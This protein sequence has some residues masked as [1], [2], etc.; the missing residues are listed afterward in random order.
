MTAV[1][2]RPATTSRA[3]PTGTIHIVDPSPLNWLFITWN[4]M[5]E[6]VRTDQDGRIV[7][8]LAESSRWIDERT[9]ELRLRSGVQFQDGERF[10]AHNIKQHFDEMQRW[11]APH[12]PGTWLNFPPESV[13]EVADD[14]TI[15]FHL[16]EPDALAPT[17]FSGFHIASSA[18]WGPNGP[19][20]GYK[21]FGSATATG[22]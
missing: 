16:P 19:G 20:F 6:P 4:T 5:E 17:K 11:P 1:E 9:L 7:H 2:E 22:E 15:R 14:N 13:A 21:K 18:F 10:T 3:T 8:A 12:P